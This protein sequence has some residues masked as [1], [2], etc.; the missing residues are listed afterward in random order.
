[1]MLFTVAIIYLRLKVE[2]Q[3]QCWLFVVVFRTG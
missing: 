1:M 2:V 3:V